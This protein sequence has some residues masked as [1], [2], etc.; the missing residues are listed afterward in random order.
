MSSYT[1]S[2]GKAAHN[3]Y[4]AFVTGPI[5]NGG[6]LGGVV[7][8]NVYLPGADLEILGRGFLTTNQWSKVTAPSD[9]I[10]GYT[11]YCFNTIV[12]KK[13]LWTIFRWRGFPGTPETPL[14]PPLNTSGS[15]VLQEICGVHVYLQTSLVRQPFLCGGG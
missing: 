2:R 10:G 12:I 13:V 9:S 7:L 5:Q 8:D 14:N 11:I 4:A 6:V 15:K 3:N 1:L